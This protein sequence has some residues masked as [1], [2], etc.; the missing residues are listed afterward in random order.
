MKSGFLVFLAA[1]LCGAIYLWMGY[2]PVWQF[3][4]LEGNARKVI[5]PD[6][7]ET[8]AADLSARY[9]DGHSFRR[10]ELGTNFPKKLLE[11]APSLGPYVSV[12]PADPKNENERIRVYWGSG[13]L[14]AKGFSIG[15]TNYVC[16][17]PG[18]MWRPGVFFYD[19]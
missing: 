13:F 11:L 19:K 10:S 12:Y 4:H 3:D 16:P 8:W 18:R 14:G 15:S 5:A 17:R 2:R 7:L 1:L 6:E 9:P